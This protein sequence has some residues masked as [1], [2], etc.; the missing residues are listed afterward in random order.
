MRSYGRPE[1]GYA[2]L[3]LAAE[4]TL[5]AVPS[6]SSL[7]TNSPRRSYR[8]VRTRLGIREYSV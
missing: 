3:E 4:R 8:R 6:A 1:F 2:R 7:T 5:E